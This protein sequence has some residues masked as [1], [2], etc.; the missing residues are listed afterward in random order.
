MA[1]LAL[2]RAREVEE[3]AAEAEEAPAVRSRVAAAV[4]WPNILGTRHRT[5]HFG[6]AV[7]SPSRCSDFVDVADHTEGAENRIVARRTAFVATLAPW[8]QA[9]C[10]AE[11]TEVLVETCAGSGCARCDRT[12]RALNGE[13]AG[14]ECVS[15]GEAK[16]RRPHVEHVDEALAVERR[17]NAADVDLADTE[18]CGEIFEAHAS[19]GARRPREGAEHVHGDDVESRTAFFSTAHRGIRGVHIE[20]GSLSLGRRSRWPSSK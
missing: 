17:Q 7:R 3:Q 14:A 8:P 19:L 5:L 9:Q 20:N 2:K 13:V 10:A 11:K 18:L 6:E 12:R 4:V 16:H 15:D 1:R